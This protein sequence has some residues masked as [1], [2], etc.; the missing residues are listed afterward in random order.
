MRGANESRPSAIERKENLAKGKNILRRSDESAMSIVPSR[1]SSRMSGYSRDS[2]RQST[3]SSELVYQELTIDDDLFTARV[4][5]RNYRNN[6]MQYYRKARQLKTT[7]GGNGTDHQVLTELPAILSRCQWAANVNYLTWAGGPVEVIIEGPPIDQ[8]I[9]PPNVSLYQEL[10]PSPHVSRFV[11]ICRL[12]TILDVLR[13]TTEDFN[14]WKQ[15]VLYEACKQKKGYL[16]KAL[17]DHGVW[18]N[19]HHPTGTAARLCQT[20]PL[21]VAACLADMEMVELL[22]KEAP[23]MG[24][25][26]RE[27]DNGYQ[28]LH[29][30]CREGS[31]DLVAK[32]IL[33]GADVNSFSQRT[34]DQPLH[35]AAKSAASSSAILHYLLHHGANPH[36]KTDQGDTALHL[37][38]MNNN[39]PKLSVLLD[40][41]PP[42]SVNDEDGWTPLHVACRYGS[43]EM[44]RELLSAGSCSYPKTKLGRNPLHVACTRGD[45]FVVEELLDWYEFDKEE[46]AWSESPLVVAVSGLRTQIVSKL[47]SYNFDPNFFYKATYTSMLHHALD[48]SCSN[49]TEYEQRLRTVETLLTFGANTGSQDH[50]GDTVLHR[51]AI[52]DASS[53]ESQDQLLLDL[54]IDHGAKLEARNLKGQ[55]PMDLAMKRGDLRKIKA[56]YLADAPSVSPES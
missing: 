3:D 22:L 34:R 47:L 8:L 35:V 37:V 24:P 52:A 42:L 39:L 20:T 56:L 49:L 9:H 28:P 16:V 46:Y 18:K 25:M 50:R 1:R 48:Q 19:G 33:A 53:V 26:L 43:R 17:L 11:E 14:E 54:L 44:V 36:A 32:L 7:P 38:C 10:V 12:T 23:E 55:T 45:L 40:W 13:S 5:K 31:L 30:A 6:I 21:H 15:C 2:R 51:W 29:I 4:Y 27:D 41:S